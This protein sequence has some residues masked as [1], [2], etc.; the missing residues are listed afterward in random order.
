MRTTVEDDDPEEELEGFQERPFK[1]RMM[2]EH[3]RGLEEDDW[4]P[5]QA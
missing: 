3:Q 4:V 5:G 1:A 2:N